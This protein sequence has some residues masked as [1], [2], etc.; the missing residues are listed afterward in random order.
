MTLKTR[1]RSEQSQACIESYARLKSL[2]LVGEEL[3]IPWQYV[4]STLRAAGV[5]VTG[6]KARYGSVKDRLA[7]RAERIFAADVPTAIDANAE[8]YQSRIDFTV[9]Q[10]SVDVKASRLHGAREETTGKTTSPRW[11]FCIK[12]QKDQSDFFV[13]YAFGESFDSE[14]QH[15][16]LMPRE[17]ATT[18]TTIVVPASL[19]SKWADY[20]I[21]QKE[22]LPFFE[23][24]ALI[25]SSR[26]A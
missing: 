26:A 23:K 11:M 7:T 16:F 21:D 1:S 9:G 12:K 2:K 17:I 19:K 6:D 4:Y 15:V 20:M 13:M 5:S 10:F 22:L 8:Q 18:A 25:D 14:V 24:M 3:G